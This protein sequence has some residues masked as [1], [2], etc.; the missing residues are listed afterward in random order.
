V[1][2]KKRIAGL[3]AWAAI[4]GLA[5]WRL[6][7]G[8]PIDALLITCSAIVGYAAAVLLT[9][10]RFPGIKR[11]E[12]VFSIGLYEGPDPFTMT[13]SKQVINPVL[14]PAD[15]T[16]V[17]ASFVADPFL[18]RRG[19]LWYMF[20]EVGNLARGMGEIGMATST[21]GLDWSYDRIVLREEHHLSYPHVLQTEDG[22]FMVPESHSA[23]AAK[24]YRAA[25]F[26][27]VWE[28]ECDLL[29][30][31]IRDA[32][33]F[34]SDGLWWVFFCDTHTHDSLRL[35]MSLSLR[36]PWEEHPS[37]P[38]VATDRT[39]ARPAG[40]VIRHGN[41][42]F[43][44]AQSAE[45]RYGSSVRAFEIHTL[46]PECYAEEPVGSEPLFRG[47]GKGWNSH[48]MHHAHFHVVEEGR[49]IA[50]VDGWTDRI[51]VMGFPLPCHPLF[52]RLSFVAGA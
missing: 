11:R 52:H 51:S 41:R 32:T 12:H 30:G 18:L 44:F 47:S 26:P 5:I 24:L 9:G 49:W 39:T 43:R 3:T 6:S 22:V 13:A 21:D 33:I 16:D 40:P 45:P 37:S 14:T 23:Y 17:T 8:F 7:H 15:V 2:Y 10:G 38:I 20:L 28:Y 34:Q 19:G 4:L 31:P 48:G 46:T 36:G 50:A 1:K 25:E 42:L 27:L 29:R 35:Y